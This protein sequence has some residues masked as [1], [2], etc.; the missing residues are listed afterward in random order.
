MLRF[1]ANLFRIANM[2]ASKE[3][4]RYYLRG[5]YVEPHHDCGV[6]LTAT[7]GVKMIVIHDEDGKADESAIINLDDVLK[8]CKS[9]RGVAPVVTIDTRATDAMIYDTREGQ[10][11]GVA[12]G[13][14]IDGTFPDYR[15]AIPRKFKNATVPAFASQHLSDLAAVGTELAAHFFTEFKPK[16]LN[17]TD[18]KDCV[19]ISAEDCDRPGGS[20]ALVSWF[21]IPQAFAVLMPVKGKSED[22]S[23]PSWFSH[24]RAT[25]DG[26]PVRQAAE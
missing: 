8:L 26:K 4:T 13:A 14:R 25:V 24:S 17:I 21:L 7:N 11:I 18:R 22:A 1:N 12:L 3:E 10:R 6:T 15:R 5:V 16:E 20:P 9:K 19:Q 23:L 2:C